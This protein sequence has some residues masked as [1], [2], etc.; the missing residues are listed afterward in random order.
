[1][2]EDKNEVR[3][4]ICMNEVECCDCC[5]KP[6]LEDEYIFCL[7]EGDHLCSEQCLLE[8]YYDTYEGYWQ[9]HVK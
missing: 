2:N 6:F 5:G 4:S 9:G 3:C 7:D 8:Y 1:M